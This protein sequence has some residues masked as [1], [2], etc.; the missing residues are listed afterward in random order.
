MALMLMHVNKEAPSIGAV[1]PDATFP[2][3]LS[4]V[5]IKALSKDA[6]DRQQSA[7]ELWAEVDAVCR[8]GNK[9][10]EEI[11]TEEWIPFDAKASLNQNRP[12]MS[13]NGSFFLAEAAKEWTRTTAEMYALQNKNKK[14][15][16]GWGQIKLGLFVCV[17]VVSVFS[18]G[19]IYMKASDIS[20]ARSLLSSGNYEG[21]IQILEGLNSRSALLGQ[22]RELLNEAYLKLAKRHNDMQSYQTAI[23]LLD[24][25][26]EKSKF[27]KEAQTLLKQYKRRSKR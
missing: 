8:G 23:D 7:E 10:L 14:F 15:K 26:N 18:V 20:S 4:A 16:L 9:R 24:R 13:E 12:Q 19:K 1:M 25:I 21:S 17:L 27:Y 2:L 22:D 5:V 3:G 6:K 11:T